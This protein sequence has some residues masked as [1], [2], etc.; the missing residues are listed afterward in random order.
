MKNWRLFMAIL[1][2]CGGQG[3]QWFGEKIKK[4]GDIL[5]EEPSEEQT[6]TD[7]LNVKRIDNLSAKP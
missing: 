1:G 6:E 5:N 7:R 2:M 4:A 3:Q